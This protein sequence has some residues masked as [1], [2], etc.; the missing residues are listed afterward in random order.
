MT[1]VTLLNTAPFAGEEGEGEEGFVTVQPPL[2]LLLLLLL[3]DEASHGGSQLRPPQ[4]SMCDTSGAV[5][6]AVPPQI[7]V[8][9]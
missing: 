8:T 3:E 5:Q 9:G 4:L 6:L 1:E 2:L 7:E